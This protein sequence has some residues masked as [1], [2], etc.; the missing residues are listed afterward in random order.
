MGSLVQ[1]FIKSG[2]SAVQF[3]EE[4]TSADLGPLQHDVVKTGLG[5]SK[6]AK[7]AKKSD[8]TKKE[9]EDEAIEEELSSVYD[10]TLQEEDDGDSV[11]SSESV[12]GDDSSMEDGMDSGDSDSSDGDSAGDSDGDIGSEMSEREI[13]QDMDSIFDL[14]EQEKR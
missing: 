3:V 8:A 7:D 4:M 6:V 1:E 5:N 9:D 10:S 12:M 13:A 14:I 11:D 2:K